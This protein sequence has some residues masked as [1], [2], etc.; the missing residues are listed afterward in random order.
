MIPCNAAYQGFLPFLRRGIAVFYHS[1][2]HN[3]HDFPFHTREIYSISYCK[4]TIYTTCK[5]SILETH[6]SGT[7]ICSR[8]LNKKFLIPSVYSFHRGER[9][10]GCQD[11]W[12]KF[13]TFSGE[14]N[15]LL[16]NYF[17]R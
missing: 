8:D 5:V 15:F 6:T 9:H 7:I 13:L 12:V 4:K 16:Q 17:N 10:S 2:K 14:A 11:I 3:T 1:T